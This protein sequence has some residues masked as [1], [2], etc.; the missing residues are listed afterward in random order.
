MFIVY[1]LK[2]LERWEIHVICICTRAPN[3][4]RNNMYPCWGSVRNGRTKLYNIDKVL[5]TLFRCCKNWPLNCGHH[6][7][8]TNLNCWKHSLRFKILLKFTT[9]TRVAEC[10]FYFIPQLEV[11]LSFYIVPKQTL[12]AV[13]NR[14][15]EMASIIWKLRAVYK[16]MHSLQKFTPYQIRSPNNSYYSQCYKIYSG[17]SSF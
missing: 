16:R 14:P 5:M 7:R 2:W 17:A 1:I 11:I 4:I 13:Q 3:D 10:S 8:Q 6:V 15:M 12:I 9:Y